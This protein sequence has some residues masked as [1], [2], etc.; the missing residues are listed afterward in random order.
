MPIADI[1]VEGNVVELAVVAID[2][3]RREVIEER[4]GKDAVGF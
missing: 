1:D 2:D 3:K 4:Y